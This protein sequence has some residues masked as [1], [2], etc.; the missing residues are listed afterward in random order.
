M[1]SGTE[2]HGCLNI[3]ISS[4]T[5]GVKSMPSTSVSR[6]ERYDTAITVT[7]C[8]KKCCNCTV[9][10]DCLTQEHLTSTGWARTCHLIPIQS[11]TLENKT[12]LEITRN[13]RGISACLS[14]AEDNGRQ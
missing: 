12:S 5:C 10:Q 3:G 14:I 13:L 2:C 9:W 1:Y 4:I 6:D 8:Y 11:N 7:V